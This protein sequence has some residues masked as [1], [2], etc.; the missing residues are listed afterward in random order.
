[1]SECSFSQTLA[2]ANLVRGL[3]PGV[4]VRRGAVMADWREIERVLV[5]YFRSH[6]IKL[7]ATPGETAVQVV[8]YLELTDDDAISTEG[9]VL[10]SLT[11]LAEHLAQELRDPP[12]D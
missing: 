2:Q 1:M 11:T 3:P 8:R 7:Y 10:F 9:V 12:T 4:T 6:H 5:D